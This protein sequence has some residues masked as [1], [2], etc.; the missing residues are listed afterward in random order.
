M[1]HNPNDKH[2]TAEPYIGRCMRTGCIKMMNDTCR[3]HKEIRRL[4]R[5]TLEEAIKKYSS[6]TEN[7]QLVQWLT[8]LKALR[9]VNRALIDEYDRL[10]KEKRELL[11]ES[12]QIYEYKRLLQAAVEDFAVYGALKDLPI[13]QRVRN[14][15]WRKFNR[16]FDILDHQWRYAEEAV[17]LLSARKQIMESPQIAIYKQLL[18]S[19]TGIIKNVDCNVVV[20]AVDDYLC[21][22]CEYHAKCDGSFSFYWKRLN[23]ASKLIGDDYT[24]K[25]EEE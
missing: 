6:D 18:K 13:E 5:M 11:K 22:E 10:V 14:S 15:D 17:K 9:E 8:E 4:S 1:T 7:Q 20:D 2:K 3:L 24:E 19:A 25:D 16:V 12:S 21:A 23:E